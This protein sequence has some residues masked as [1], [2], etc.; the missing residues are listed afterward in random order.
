MWGVDVGVEVRLGW[1]WVGVDEGV[2]GWVLGVG[3]GVGGVKW[4]V[5]IYCCN[6]VGVAKLESVCP[7]SESWNGCGVR[8]WGKCSPKENPGK[9]CKKKIKALAFTCKRV[10]YLSPSQL[11]GQRWSPNHHV[12]HKS[13]GKR[14]GQTVNQRGTPQEPVIRVNLTSFKGWFIR[15][16]KSWQ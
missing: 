13:L 1:G 2:G 10:A 11:S 4:R 5:P 15:L 16:G 9:K 6:A 3:V 7:N 12:L 8:Y 14:Q